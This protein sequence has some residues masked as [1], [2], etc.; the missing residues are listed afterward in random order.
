MFNTNSLD[1]SYFIES[2]SLTELERIRFQLKEEYNKAAG[3]TVPRVKSVTFNKVNSSLHLLKFNNSYNNLT[4]NTIDQS[5]QLKEKF[6]SIAEKH[7]PTLI[8]STKNFYQNQNSLPNSASSRNHT[9]KYICINTTT[10]K[11]DKVKE[12][13]VSPLKLFIQNNGVDYDIGSTESITE[14]KSDSSN[15]RKLSRQNSKENSSNKESP[16]PKFNLNMLKNNGKQFVLENRHYVT[17]IC[18][19]GK[20]YIVPDQ[21]NNPNIKFVN[22]NQQNVR[23]NFC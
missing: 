14:L 6:R 5:L 18:V 1:T 7:Q 11:V 20:S 15:L 9:R 2:E 22:K 17:P 16:I 8:N 3:S 12:K 23:K 4:K 19:S 10:A 13:E 21:L